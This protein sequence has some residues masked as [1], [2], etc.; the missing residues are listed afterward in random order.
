MFDLGFEVLVYGDAAAIVHF[1]AC[2]GQVEIVGGALAAYGVEQGIAGDFL[3]ALQVGN[4]GRVGELLDAFDLF[5]QAEGDAVVAQVIAEGFDNLAIGEFEK[6]VAFFDERDADAEDSEHAGVFDADYAAADYDQRA[7]QFRQRE[8]LVAVDDR[9]AVDGDFGRSR[10]PGS[11]G[12][13]DA[14]GLERRV[15]LRALNAHL[16]RI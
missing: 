5:A 6:A 9:P 7:G 2:G 10:G 8:D 3:L 13:D 15:S 11:D 16:V 1:D 14:I 12:E 4:H